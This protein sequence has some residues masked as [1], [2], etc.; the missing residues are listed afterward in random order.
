MQVYLTNRAP[1]SQKGDF[2]KG[3]KSILNWVAKENCTLLLMSS[4]VHDFLYFI[5]YIYVYVHKI[6]EALAEPQCFQ[7]SLGWC[8][9][10]SALTEMR[11]KQM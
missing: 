6:T 1:L 11:V 5:S 10:S 2:S 9:I 4:S 3:F 7:S 8:V